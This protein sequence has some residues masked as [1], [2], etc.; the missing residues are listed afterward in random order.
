[1]KTDSIFIEFRN[2]VRIFEIII[3]KFTGFKNQLYDIESAV[4]HLH[5]ILFVAFISTL[6]AL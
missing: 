3:K 1:M 4:L 2:S 5:K 6:Q